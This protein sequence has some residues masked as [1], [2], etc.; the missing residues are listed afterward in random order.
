MSTEK[1]SWEKLW[2]PEAVGE[3]ALFI[4]GVAVS[5]KLVQ[6]LNCIFKFLKEKLSW[7]LLQHHFK[8]A[9]SSLTILLKFTVTLRKPFDA[10]HMGNVFS[11]S[12]KR[13]GSCLSP[14]TAR[15]TS[16]ARRNLLLDSS[17]R[18]ARLEPA[19]ETLFS[20]TSK[21]VFSFWWRLR[22]TG[23]FS[24]RC[25]TEELLWASSYRR[26]LGGRTGTK[27]ILPSCLRN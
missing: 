24:A 12:G 8:F 15:Q 6:S 7:I 16:V 20:S 18:H 27:F 14:R 3:S 10:F 25:M 19:D 5:A 4:N 2:F 17:H 26:A 11:W 21:Q 1:R 13:A 9:C 23:W 22:G